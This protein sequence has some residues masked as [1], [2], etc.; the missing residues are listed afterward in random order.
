M[1]ATISSSTFYSDI[2][3]FLFLVFPAISLH[4]LSRYVRMSGILSRNER[5]LMH[6]PVY[7]LATN[8]ALR[9]QLPQ[10]ISAGV[11]IL[12]L[13]Y[14]GTPVAE[15]LIFIKPRNSIHFDIKSTKMGGSMVY[16]SGSRVK[17]EI[18]SMD[19]NNKPIPA[20]FSVKVLVFCFVLFCFVL[21][22]FV[23]FCFVLFCFVLFCFVLFC[24]V[25]FCFIHFCLFLAYLFTGCRQISIQEDRA[26]PTTSE[27][28]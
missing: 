10:N 12:T 7:P 17:L 11:H 6:E 23:L 16:M 14:F 22:C 3:N 20:V 4:F 21:F 27:N 18:T 25:L 5:I 2:F 9:F 26:T 24:F 13:T 8:S 1:E 28:K 15:R 19:A